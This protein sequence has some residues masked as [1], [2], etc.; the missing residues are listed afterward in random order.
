MIVIDNERSLQ[1]KGVWA[2][3]SGSKFKIA[4]AGNVQFQRTLNKLQLPYRRQMDR[5]TMDPA[6]SKEILCK[7]MAS[8]L[9]LDWK[10]VQ[11]SK[12]EDVVY[13][14]E[15]AIMALVNNDDLREFIQDFSTDLE[16]FRSE[17]VEN[18]G[19]S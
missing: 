19:K 1:E 9:L 17:R 3:Y 16:N 12:G 14:E 18:E 6:V 7:A 2:D 13:S 11:N 8:G 4:H 5:G 15:F 10:S